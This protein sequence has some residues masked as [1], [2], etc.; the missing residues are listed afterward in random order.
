MP[1]R[2]DKA[3]R[4]ILK[5]IVSFLN[6]RGGTIY[7]GIEDSK[8]AVQGQ[9][10]DRKTRDNFRLWLKQMLE[11][12]HPKVDLNNRQ[13]VLTQY[14]PVKR[15]GDFEGKYVVKVIVKQGDPS[16]VYCFGERIKLEGSNGKWEDF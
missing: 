1:L 11:K 8:G 2:E 12:V 10:L 6:S 9:F 3:T 16:Q 7:I 4:T 5:T 13:E 15:G 14:I